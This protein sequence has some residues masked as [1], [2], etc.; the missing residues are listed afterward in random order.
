MAHFA[1]GDYAQATQALT[2]AGTLAWSAPG[3]IHLLDFHFYSAL[4]LSL[5]LTPETF[6][7][8]YR[9]R[10]HQHYDKIALWARVNPGTFA[11]KEALVYAEIVRLDG[12]NSIALEQYERAITLSRDAGFTPYHA[13]AHELAGRFARS[14]GYTTTADAHYRGAIAAWGRAGAQARCDSWSRRFRTC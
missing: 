1:C 2:Q 7:A 8:E 4:S 13:L 3:H 6:S 5:Q 10:I 14:C 11:D 12:M 9:R